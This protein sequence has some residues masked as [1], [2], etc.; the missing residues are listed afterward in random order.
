MFCPCF[1]V[2]VCTFPASQVCISLNMAAAGD[3][4]MLDHFGFS[5][6]NSCLS[7][8]MR[9]SGA[10]P[11]P[12]CRTQCQVFLWFSPLLLFLCALSVTLLFHL[13]HLPASYLFQ[14]FFF[15]FP[16]TILFHELMFPVLTDFSFCMGEW[17]CLM[18]IRFCSMRTSSVIFL[19]RLQG[20]HNFAFALETELREYANKLY[21]G[22]WESHLYS[23]DHSAAFPMGT[24]LVMWASFYVCTWCGQSA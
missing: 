18:L 12:G 10:F 14:V 17:K 2:Y 7:S 20:I 11:S 15:F 3:M 24:F 5:E 4:T 21:I 16:P 8:P 22:V 23:A 9:A 13:F 6:I 1:Y 19:S